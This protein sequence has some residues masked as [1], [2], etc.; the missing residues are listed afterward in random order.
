M[1]PSV[2]VCLYAQSL[3]MYPTVIPAGDE[4]GNRVAWR[5]ATVTEPPVSPTLTLSITLTHFN[6]H[7]TLL[8]SLWLP[9]CILVLQ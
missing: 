9:G 2:S 7:I 8:P 6:F 3:C 5:G 4:A 1:V